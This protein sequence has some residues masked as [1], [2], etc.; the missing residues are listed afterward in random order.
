M[1]RVIVSLSIFF[2]LL[3]GSQIFIQGILC[4]ATASHRKAASV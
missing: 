2:T 4:L 1:R 3:H